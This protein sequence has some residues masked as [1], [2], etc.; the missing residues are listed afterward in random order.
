MDMRLIRNVKDSDRN[1]FYLMSIIHTPKN[2]RTVHW[3]YP[4]KKSSLNS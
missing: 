3:V 2:R 4:G 1:A